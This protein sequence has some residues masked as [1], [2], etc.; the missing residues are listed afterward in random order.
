MRRV[1]RALM[2]VANE[3]MTGSCFRELVCAG[4]VPGSR[5][6]CSQT[7]VAFGG[8]SGRLPGVGTSLRRLRRAVP[9]SSVGC[10][11]PASAEELFRGRTPS[12]P[13]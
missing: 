3:A 10:E 6:S 1:Y 4:S 13:P 5:L 7:Q 12:V 8:D 2:L 11:V 9:A